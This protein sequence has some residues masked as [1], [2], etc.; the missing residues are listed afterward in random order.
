MVLGDVEET[1]TVVDVN[2]ETLEEVIRVRWLSTLYGVMMCYT[3]IATGSAT[4]GQLDIW[5]GADA[6][7]PATKQHP[8]VAL[9]SRG[10][11]NDICQRNNKMGP[12]V[13]LNTCHNPLF[14]ANIQPPL[15]V[16]S[17]DRQEELRDAFCPWRRCDLGKPTY[18]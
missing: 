1:I 11:E 18:P 15:H 2:D 10:L 4:T 13:L 5:T 14:F 6:F 8:V 17:T 3:G 16:I 9:K 7:T 12:R